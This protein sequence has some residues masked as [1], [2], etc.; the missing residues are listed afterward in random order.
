V[1][2]FT[3][4]EVQ[5]MMDQQSTAEEHTPQLTLLTNKYDTK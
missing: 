2:W 3:L 4:T 1:K 5:M